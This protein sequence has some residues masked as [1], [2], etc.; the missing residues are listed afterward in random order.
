MPN[1]VSYMNEKN[2]ETK[3]ILCELNTNKFKKRP[4]FSAEMICYSLELR[5]TL[6]QAY[7]I[8]LVL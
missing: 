1:F 7:N 6:L 3:S 2:E 4:F 5:Y 8:Y